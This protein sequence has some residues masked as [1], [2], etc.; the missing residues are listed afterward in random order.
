MVTLAEEGDMV[1]LSGGGEC[2]HNVQGREEVV[3]AGSW[4]ESQ[5]AV[6]TFEFFT[7][8]PQYKNANIANFVLTLSLKIN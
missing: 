6:K 5:T 1:T 8:S 4:K 2:G 3:S 7:V